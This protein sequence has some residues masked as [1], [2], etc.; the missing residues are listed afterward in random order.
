[1]PNL[2]PFTKLRQ[3][4][5]EEF[6]GNR[7]IPFLWLLIGGFV[8]VLYPTVLITEF[9]DAPGGRTLELFKLYPHMALM[10]SLLFWAI[11]WMIASSL[12]AAWTDKSLRPKIMQ[13]TALCLLVS[14]VFRKSVV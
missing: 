5:A 11:F 3:F 7:W 9:W 10:P 13:R 8:C 12:S 14:T 2:R 6:S 4:F 1:M